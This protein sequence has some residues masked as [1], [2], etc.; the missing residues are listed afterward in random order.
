MFFVLI[1]TSSGEEKI[2]INFLNMTLGAGGGADKQEEIL[3]YMYTMYILC[4]DQAAYHVA[5]VSFILEKHRYTPSLEL[6][7][8]H[9]LC[10]PGLGIGAP[11]KVSNRL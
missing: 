9:G 11:A 7:G 1:S 4:S 8:D 2:Q 5:Y 3:L 10:C 6:L